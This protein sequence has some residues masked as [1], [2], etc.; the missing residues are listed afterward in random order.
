VRQ[1]QNNSHGLV[2]GQATDGFGRAT[3]NRFTHMMRQQRFAGVFFGQ[4]EAAG[5]GRDQACQQTQTFLHKGSNLV[6]LGQDS[7]R[8]F[9]VARIVQQIA[10]N[11]VEF[12]MKMIST[13]KVLGA[14]F[15]EAKRMETHPTSA[16]EEGRRNTIVYRT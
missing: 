16:R 5:S 7:G 10:S 8:V 2:R 14:L 11:S 6:S 4:G 1:C 3:L 12:L 9:L 13:Q 15:R